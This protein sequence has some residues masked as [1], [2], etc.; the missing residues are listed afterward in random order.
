MCLPDVG[1]YTHARTAA[2]LGEAE[3]EGG[4][5]VLVV[6]GGGGTGGDKSDGNEVQPGMKGEGGAAGEGEEAQQGECV[7]VSVEGGYCGWWRLE[8]RRS[9]E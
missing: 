3:G 2:S 9:A 4:V 8:R 5:E 6:V 7:V 1:S